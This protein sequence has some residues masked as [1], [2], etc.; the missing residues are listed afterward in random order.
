MRARRRWVLPLVVVIAWLAIGGPLGSFAGRLAEVQENDNA[1]FLPSAAESTEVM[2]AQAEFVGDEAVPAIVV[3][4][5]PAGLDDADLERIADQAAGLSGIDLVD[6][7]RILPPIGALEQSPEQLV[8]DD[9]QAIQLVLPISTSD[10]DQLQ[11]VIL[12]I[13]AT[14]DG[15]TATDGMTAYVTGPAGIL[16]DF[17]EAFGAIDGLLLVVALI[18]VLVILLAVYRSP[19]LPLVV[20]FSAV[21][22]LGTA[23]AIVYALASTDRLDLNGQSQGILFILV[24]G[25]ATDYALLLISRYRE[26][27]REHESVVDAMRVAWRGAVAPIVASAL[28]V[29]LGLLC[30]LL[31]DL[32][33]LRGLGPVG[34]IGVAMSMVVALTF[35]PATLLLLGRAAF[36]PRRPTYASEHPQ[37]RGIWGRVARMVGERPRRVWIAVSLVLLAL[38]ALAPQ[39]ED[40]G[41]PQTDVFLTDVESVTGQDV[42][43]AHFSAGSGDPTYVL[44]GQQ[45]AAQASRIIMATD[46]V[47]DQPVMPQ[48]AAPPSAQ[49]DRSEAGSTS[50]PDDA[51]VVD[52]QVLLQVTLTDQPD[53]AAAEATVEQLRSDVD[54]VGT[55]VLVGGTTALQLDALNTSVRDRNVVIPTILLVVFLVLALL[56]RSLVAPLLL[57]VANVLSFAATLGVAAMVFNHVF[58][59][60]GGDPSV[61]LIAFVFLV[62]LGIDYSIF[63]MTRVREESLRGDTR[64]A[65][66]KGLTVTGGVIT[67]AGVVLAAT[68]SALGVLPILFLAQIAFLVA[69]GVL[70]DTIVVRSLLVPA[71]SYDIGR[72]IWWPGG[73]ASTARHRKT[74]SWAVDKS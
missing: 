71:L 37:S 8:S 61:T 27:L 32:T 28:T 67:S 72:L 53:T 34:A 50:A 54:V 9:G 5:D 4:E 13:R 31:S 60:A 73:L 3:W 12:D 33:S 18:V 1:A 69:F 56:L 74:R 39:F 43:N 24:V 62:A 23:S 41:V 21:L 70:L 14:V 7:D 51:T 16:G 59:F 6:R 57:I 19:L 17:T 15:G 52:G 66:L 30:L 63:L 2:E 42:L 46:G 25:A 47:A 58:N 49:G 44:V 65:I 36:W 29:V 35:L 48:G 11:E 22:A 68:F 45:D 26:E 10:S 40:E 38:A 20:L 64:P 55:D